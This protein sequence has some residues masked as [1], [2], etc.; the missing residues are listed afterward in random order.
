VSLFDLEFSVAVRP[1]FRVLVVPVAIMWVNSACRR[2]RHEVTLTLAC[3]CCCTLSLGELDPGRDHSV[4][5]QGLCSG[6]CWRR[7][8][9]P[10][11][12]NVASEV[13]GKLDL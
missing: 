9:L 5:S 4:S 6:T 2:L 11:V 10:V 3:H 8:L 7:F 12:E 1:F 13:A